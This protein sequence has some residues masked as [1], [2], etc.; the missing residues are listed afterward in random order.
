MKN[1]L[2]S[3][4]FLMESFGGCRILDWQSF[5]FFSTFMLSDYLLASMVSNEKSVNLFEDTLHARSNF[6]IFALRFSFFWLSGVWLWCVSRWKSLWVYYTWTLLSF[7]DVYSNA[8]LLNL[9]SFHH[10]FFKILSDY[11]FNKCPQGK[12]QLWCVSCKSGQTNT[13]WWVL[14]SRETPGIQIMTVLWE[15]VFEG[16]LSLLLL[17]SVRLLF[18]KPIISY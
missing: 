17:V 3:P 10:C 5:F 8:L 12:K 4:L 9:K 6:S 18:Y 15:W 14:Y 7:L 1:A 2:I 16:V 11:I 13:I